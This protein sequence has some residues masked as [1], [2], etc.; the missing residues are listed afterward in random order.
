MIGGPQVIDPT[1]QD[2]VMQRNMDKLKMM[3]LIEFHLRKTLYTAAPLC[4]KKC[5][6]YKNA[7]EVSQ[8]KL[9]ILI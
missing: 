9:S 5:D 4:V 2:R 3:D 6:T 7:F 1:P 8:S